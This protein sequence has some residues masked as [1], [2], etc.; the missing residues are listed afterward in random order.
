MWNNFNMFD[1]FDYKKTKE[2][3]VELNN[4]IMNFWKDFYNDVFSTV[5]KDI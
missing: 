5:K 4:K 3:Y 2:N 1:L